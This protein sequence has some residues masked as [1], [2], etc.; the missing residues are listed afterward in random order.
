MERAEMVM[1]PAAMRLARNPTATALLFVLAAALVAPT[2]A[3]ADAVVTQCVDAG[4]GGLQAA[5][6]AGGNISFTCAPAR[7]AVTQTHDIARNIVLNGSDGITLDAGGRT[8]T[9]F[10]LAANGVT[11]TLSHLTVQGGKAPQPP[12]PAPGTLPLVDFGAAGSVVATSTH[13]GATITLQSV[14]VQDNDNP[15]LIYA[16]DTTSPNRL[17]VRNTQFQNNTGTAVALAGAG[18]TADIDQ[19]SFVG[20]AVGLGIAGSA[21]VAG[22]PFSQN[23]GAAISVLVG[24]TLD[25]RYSDFSGNTGADGAALTINGKAK[26]VTVRSANFTGNVASGQGGAISIYPYRNLTHL[27]IPPPPGAVSATMTYVTFTGSRAQ[28][29]GALDADLSD[30]G[31]LQLAAALFQGNAAAGDGG[32]LYVTGGSTQISGAIFK[33]NTTGAR[34]AA[35]ILLAPA[36][37]QGVVANVLAVGNTAPA[38]GGAIGGANLELENVTIADNAGGGLGSQNSTGIPSGQF[39]LHNTILTGN[40]PAN[41]LGVPAGLAAGGANLQFPKETSCGA[42]PAADPLLDPIYAPLPGS[43]AYG[44]GELAIC[45]KSLVNGRDVLFQKRGLNGLCSIG[46]MEFAPEH[47]MALRAMRGSGGNQHPGNTSP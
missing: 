40:S 37:S 23:H 19:S 10:R 39:I 12:V 36:T 6:Q 20:N 43:P 26:A 18:A 47:W 16:A 8:L 7:I 31:H 5:L 34:G 27:P 32:G 21:T 14:Q 42:I 30:G 2:P 15:V 13:T 17:V 45:L 28:R 35:A 3:L 38:G 1:R 9:M 22:T 11:L 24:G 41:C 25:L 33:T 4:P 44:T 29:G 46:A